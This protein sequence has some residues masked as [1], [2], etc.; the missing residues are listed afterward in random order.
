MPLNYFRDGFYVFTMTYYRDDAVTSYFEDN[1]PSNN[2]QYTFE[3]RDDHEDIF[4][5]LD[6]YNDRQYPYGCKSST[7]GTIEL[8]KNGKSLGK[9]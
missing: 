8:S 1:S 5:G 7:K 3:L 9:K 4:V 6:F 2:R